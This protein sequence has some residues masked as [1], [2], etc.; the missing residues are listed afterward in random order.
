MTKDVL[1]QYTDLLREKKEVEERIRKTEQKIRQLEEE[2]EV[3]DVV[4]GGEGG[5]QH[6]TITGFPMRDY[7][8]TKSLL[9]TR[10]ITLLSLEA[11][12]ES[13]LTDV[14]EFIASIDNSHDRRVISMRIVDKMSWRQ[15]AQNLGGNNTEDSVRKRFERFLDKS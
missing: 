4:S 3:T 7:T 6:Y 1:T 12:I 8:R 9:S 2:G 11:E 5:I 14:Y 15:I 13:T 10:R